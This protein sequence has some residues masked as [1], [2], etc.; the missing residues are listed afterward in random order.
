MRFLLP[1]FILSFPL[2]SLFSFTPENIPNYNAYLHSHSYVDRLYIWNEVATTTLEHPWL[3]IGI[4]GTSHHE[5][6]HAIRKWSYVDNQGTS[7]DMHSPRFGRHPHNA[8]LQLWLELGIMGLILGTLL[9]YLTVYQIYRTNF[10]GSLDKA[11]SAG[12]FTGTFIIVWV[13][14]GFWQNWWISG[15]WVIIGLTIMSFKRKR[16]INESVL[17]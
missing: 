11:V 12:L 15:L 10:L 2:V 9:A 14:L 16:E 3:G 6:A 7:H 1:I 13:N 8:I 4:D 17:S 5:K